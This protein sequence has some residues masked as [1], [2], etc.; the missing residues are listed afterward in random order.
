MIKLIVILVL[1]VLAIWGGILFYASKS[2]HDLL[3]ESTRL[4]EAIAGLT[5]ED[6]IGYARVLKQETTPEGALL[7]TL[8]FVETA[9]DD[10][11]KKILQKDYTIEGDIIHFD[12]LVVTF[13]APLVM[14]GRERSLYLWRRVYGEKTSPAEGFPIEGMGTE[15]QRYQD[16]FRRLGRTERTTFWNGI[17]DL[18]NDPESLKAHGIRAVYGNVVYARLRPGLI[19][20]FRISNT[21]HLYPETVPEM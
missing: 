14:D 10:K 17:W 4:K 15:P 19:Y 21:G 16:I 13:P 3:R 18:A 9:R 8:R 6:Q 7:T 2:I 5:A 11:L 1:V 12:A 20:V